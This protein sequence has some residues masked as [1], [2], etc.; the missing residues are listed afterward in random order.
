LEALAAKKKKI[1]E[2]VIVAGPKRGNGR[3]KRVRLEKAKKRLDEA[4]KREK[5]PWEVRWLMN[6]L[7][8]GVSY[9]LVA[10]LL[11]CII[12]RKYPRPDW[13]TDW[14]EGRISEA[15]LPLISFNITSS[16]YQRS[17]LIADEWITN[18]TGMVDRYYSEAYV[19]W[20]IIA[21]ITIGALE[22]NN[23]HSARS[24]MCYS[25]S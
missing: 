19:L 12:S 7:G 5:G 10:H 14:K 23:L 25:V 3:R 22:F 20:N 21:L 6:E 1:A 18:W 8:C 24:T 16:I 15:G 11:V 2:G 17:E 13:L 4:R 9:A